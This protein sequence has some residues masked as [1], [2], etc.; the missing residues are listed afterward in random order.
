M[1]VTGTGAARG[2]RGGEVPQNI[3][4]DHKGVGGGGSGEGQH[5]IT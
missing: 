2:G 4:F 3:T 1:F 5:L